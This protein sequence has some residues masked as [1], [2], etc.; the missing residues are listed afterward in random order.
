MGDQ[1]ARKRLQCLTGA[2]LLP[3]REQ[4]RHIGIDRLRNRILKRQPVMHAVAEMLEAQLRVLQEALGRQRLQ[5][6]TL[7]REIRGQVEL[8]ERHP[9]LHPGGHAFID[10]C[11]VV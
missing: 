2:R 1:L 5:P 9:G 6:A 7:L 4:P 8:I 3:W 11:V 10:Y